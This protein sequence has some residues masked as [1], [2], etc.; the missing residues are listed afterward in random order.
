MKNVYETIIRNLNEKYGIDSNCENLLLTLA[1]LKNG[2]SFKIG[3]TYTPIVIVEYA[4]FLRMYIRENVFKAVNNS[5]FMQVAKKTKSKEDYVYVDYDIGD[6]VSPFIIQCL[7]YAMSIYKPAKSFGCCSRY[8][9]CSNK[10]ECVH[11]NKLY[12]K[13]CWYRD[14]LEKGKIFYGKNK[15]C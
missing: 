1:D 12:A 6:N 3:K 5:Y 9:D 10:K 15:N 8:N 13:Q 11:P 7:D 2:Y 4:K 14:N